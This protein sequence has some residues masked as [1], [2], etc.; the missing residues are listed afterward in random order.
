MG[1]N[2][3]VSNNNKTI[4]NRN[5]VVTTSRVSKSR[6]HPYYDYFILIL[7]LCLLLV[8]NVYCQW[9]YLYRCRRC[10]AHFSHARKRLFYVC[11]V[12][13]GNNNSF[14]LSWHLLESLRNRYW[15]GLW[16][17]LQ[18]DYNN[19]RCFNTEKFPTLYLLSTVKLNPGIPYLLRC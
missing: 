8:R 12:A 3:R 19:F 7:R 15:I 16:K 6:E 9:F 13:Q 5:K 11:F 4:I 10:S 2:C 1:P 18:H 14:G 17:L